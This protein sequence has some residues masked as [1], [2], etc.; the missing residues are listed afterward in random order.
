[1][2]N[3]EAM[4]TLVRWARRRTIHEMGFAAT[5]TAS[6]DDAYNEGVLD[7]HIHLARQVLKEMEYDYE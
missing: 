2:T 4:N 7:G 6:H 3:A 1:M 5:A